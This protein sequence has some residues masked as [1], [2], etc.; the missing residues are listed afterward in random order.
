MLRKLRRQRSLAM[1]YHLH[2]LGLASQITRIPRAQD[3]LSLQ[4]LDLHTTRSTDHVQLVHRVQ[5]A[6]VVLQDLHLIRPRPRTITVCQSAR[7]ILLRASHTIA[8]IHHDQI[9]SLPNR[10]PEAKL[11]LLESR[12]L[13]ISLGLERMTSPLRKDQGKERHT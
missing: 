8:Q 10:H 12:N 5:Q 4:H 9:H 7:R 6:H 1:L 11:L 3:L 13:L 2:S